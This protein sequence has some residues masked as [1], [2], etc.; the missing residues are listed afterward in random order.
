MN[1]IENRSARRQAQG[2]RTLLHLTKPPSAKAMEE[3][4]KPFRDYVRVLL[5]KVSK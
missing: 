1:P 5:E 4:W 2:Q 3:V